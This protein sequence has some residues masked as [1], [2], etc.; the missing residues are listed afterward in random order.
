MLQSL[1]QARGVNIQQSKAA[2]RKNDCM[3]TTSWEERKT[4]LKHVDCQ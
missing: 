4:A 1:A 2:W 3:N